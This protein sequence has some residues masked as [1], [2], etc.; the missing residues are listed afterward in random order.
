VIVLTTFTVPFLSHKRI[1]GVQLD[2]TIGQDFRGM[3]TPPGEVEHLY[4]K[5]YVLGFTR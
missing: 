1:L 5:R 4:I 2:T 3:G